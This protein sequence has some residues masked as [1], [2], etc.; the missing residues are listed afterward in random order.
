MDFCFSSV[1]EN[2]QSFLFKCGFS[3]FSILPSEV[4]IRCIFDL[5]ILSLYLLCLIFS[6]FLFSCATFWIIYYDVSSNSFILSSAVLLSIV[7]SGSLSDQDD[8]S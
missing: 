1:L 3:V 2:F 4:F 6:I 5:V 7:N 8:H